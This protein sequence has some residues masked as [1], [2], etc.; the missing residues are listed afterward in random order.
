[1]RINHNIAA[2]NTYR[3]LSQ[4]QGVVSKHLERLSSGLRINRASDDAA[5]LAVSEKMRTQIRG[6]AMAERNSQDAVSLIQTAEGALDTV[7]SMLQRMRELAV[8]SANGT[9]TETDRKALQAE[10]NALT[11]EINRIGNTLEFNTKKL[12]DGSATVNTITNVGKLAG[13]SDFVSG[14]LATGSVTVPPNT[15]AIA[16]SGNSSVLN[17]YT[18]IMGT[19]DPLA[20]AVTAKLNGRTIEVTGNWSG[21]APLPTYQDIEDAINTELTLQGLEKIDVNPP[22]G[23][24]SGDPLSGTFYGGLAITLNGGVADNP[25]KAATRTLQVAATPHQG[26][27]FIMTDHNGNQLKLGFWDSSDPKYATKADAVA[28]L[29]VTDVIDIY[30]AGSYKSSSAI[31]LDIAAWASSNPILSAAGGYTFNASDPGSDL[32]ITAK[33]AGK[34]GNSFTTSFEYSDDIGLKV[35]I[36]A[37]T[38]QELLVDIPTVRS[39]IL[40]LTGIT[41]ASDVVSRDGK[42]IAKLTKE[43]VVSDGVGDKLVEYAL[44]ITDPANASAAITIFDDA[45]S[46]VSDTR[47]KLG[48]YQNRLEYTI[49][50]LQ[51]SNENLTAAE[52]R[53]R[54]ADMALEMTNFTKNNII[55]QAATAML[56][57][58]NQLPQGLLQLLQ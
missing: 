57:Q 53:V 42:T 17:G 3:Q 35:Q 55:N 26:D 41:A 12:L 33:V 2:L 15:L 20:T 45:I 34:L 25:A 27:I 4:S 44:D 32:I 36:G 22:A 19:S 56:A 5:G 14:S 11:T 49:S 29:G 58:A 46:Y 47:A 10:V 30:V 13:G 28:A 31:T 38:G 8:Q 21:A 48:A 7:H 9:N 6:L 43:K 51:V 52:S 18:I 1:M 24:A 37:N 23:D 16:S 39:E 54:D 50:N 40:H